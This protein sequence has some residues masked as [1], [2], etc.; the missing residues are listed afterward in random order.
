MRLNGQYSVVFDTV[1]SPESRQWAIENTRRG[2]K[3]VFLGF[4]VPMMELDMSEIIR[5]QKQLI[6]SFVYSREQFEKAIDLAQCCS[7]SWVQFFGFSDMEAQLQRF[8]T[9]DFSCIKAAF[10]PEK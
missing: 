3:I 5:H 10:S 1:G 8:A 6:G 7:D 2:G 9:G 4:A